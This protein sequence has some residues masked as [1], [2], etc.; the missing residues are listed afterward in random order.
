MIYL[1]L[2]QISLN[3][4]ILRLEP[5]FF[6]C[7]LCSLVLLMY[8]RYGT[9]I[10]DVPTDSRREY[11][12]DVFHLKI[13]RKSVSKL[14]GDKLVL[15]RSILGPDKKLGIIGEIRGDDQINTVHLN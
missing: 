11:L 9:N 8:I 13:E 1:N 2:G 7:G 4:T 15:N 10:S 6:N 5:K 3:P 12:A 14:D